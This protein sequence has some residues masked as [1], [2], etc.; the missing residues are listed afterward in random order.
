M[1]ILSINKLV[2]K[3]LIIRLTTNMI[4]D[5]RIQTCTVRHTTKKVGSYEI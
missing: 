5:S 1:I 2:N 4:L 3:K